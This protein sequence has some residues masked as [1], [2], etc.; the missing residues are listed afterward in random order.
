[1]PAAD[2]LACGGLPIGLAHGVRVIR[3]VSKGKPVGWRD[4]AVPES[5][6]ARVRLQLESEF[7]SEWGIQR[8]NAATA[9]GSAHPLQA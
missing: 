6:A 3:A 5:E 9:Q 7:R 1:M 4:V 2:S 8:L